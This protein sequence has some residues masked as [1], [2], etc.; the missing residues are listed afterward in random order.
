[1]RPR[2]DDVDERSD[3]VRRAAALTLVAA[4]ALVA[5][6]LVVHDARVTL[7]DREGGH[8]LFKN[9]FAPRFPA[10]WRAREFASNVSDPFHVSED[11]V[12]RLPN[13]VYLVPMWVERDD[14]DGALTTRKC[15]AR[16]RRNGFDDWVL[17]SRCIDGE[18]EERLDW[19]YPP[20]GNG[21][22]LWSPIHVD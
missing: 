14:P 7:H 9:F 4:C 3:R 19:E 10:P 11:D 20:C 13:G 18:A 1:M 17:E 21:R 15:I 6:V 16:W 12:R 22:E 2:E 5:L 8:A